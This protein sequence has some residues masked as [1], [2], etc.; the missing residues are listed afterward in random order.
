MQTLAPQPTK[1]L[2]IYN[3]PSVIANYYYANSTT[4][5]QDSFIP[6]Y[7]D[8]IEGEP[9]TPPPAGIARMEELGLTWNNPPLPDE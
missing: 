6:E 4:Y 1:W 3:P 5:C 9:S 7:F 2:L 8:Y